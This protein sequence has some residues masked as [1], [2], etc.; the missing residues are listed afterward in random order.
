MLLATRFLD[1]PGTVLPGRIM[2]HM[3]IMAT[4]KPSLPI[5]FI[6]QLKTHDLLFHPQLHSFAAKGYFNSAANMQ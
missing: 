3:L 4:L 2:P 5:P 1:N 6:I